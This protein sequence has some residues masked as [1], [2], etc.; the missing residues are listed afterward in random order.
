MKLELTILL[1]VAVWPVIGQLALALMARVT[2]ARG[3]GG[4]QP[5]EG[6]AEVLARMYLWPIVLWRVRLALRE[7][8]K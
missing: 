1:V 3:K 2:Q 6:V 5:A 7:Q 8:Q 4:L